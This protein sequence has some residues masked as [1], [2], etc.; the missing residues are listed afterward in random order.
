[1]AGEEDLGARRAQPPIGLEE[2]HGVTGKRPLTAPT[3]PLGELVS[4]RRR[5]GRR[6]RRCGGRR[7][8]RRI[9]RWVEDLG[10]HGNPH[11]SPVRGGAQPSLSCQPGYP[12]YRRRESGARPHETAS[13]TTWPS[14]FRRAEAGR[15]VPIVAPSWRRA[16][17]RSGP[18]RPCEPT[19]YAVGCWRY[20]RPRESNPCSPQGG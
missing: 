20:R 12:G 2:Q 16:T 6:A 11:S 19:R 10:S 15:S 13:I 1:M 17:F 8:G 5:G 9:G 18:A 7:L 3:A 14:C 4:R